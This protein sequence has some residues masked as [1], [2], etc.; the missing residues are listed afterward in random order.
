MLEQVNMSERY[1]KWVEEVAEVFGGLDICAVEAI[2]SKD[3]KEYIIEVRFL[4]L[5]TLYQ[6]IFNWDKIK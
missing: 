6:I 1:K 3:G 4:S 2:V 5:F